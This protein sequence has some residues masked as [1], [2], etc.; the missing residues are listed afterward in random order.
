MTRVNGFILFIV[1]LVFFCCGAQQPGYCQAETED[2]FV[3]SKENRRDPFVSSLDKDSP[4]GLR[5]SFEAP[6]E[7]IKLPVEFMLKGILSKGS[8]LYAII[9]DDVLRKGDRLGQVVIRDIRQDKVILEY[10]GREFTLS[11]RRE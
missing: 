9:N 2:S 6:Q 1:I 8:E 7:D 4:T 3:Y 10:A 5:I 11:L